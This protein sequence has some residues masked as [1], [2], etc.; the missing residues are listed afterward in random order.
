MVKGRKS[1]SGT[2]GA[3]TLVLPVTEAETAEDDGAPLPSRSGAPMWCWYVLIGL[4]G[5]PWKDKHE[6]G[7][8]NEV[9]E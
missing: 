5:A 4:G 1:L 2:G 6:Y 3:M 8:F 7:K 9:M